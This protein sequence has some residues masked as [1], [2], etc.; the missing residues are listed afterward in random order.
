MA[1][2]SLLIIS[3]KRAVCWGCS[4]VYVR[5]NVS[6]ST[7]VNVTGVSTTNSAAVCINAIPN[8]A[9]APAGVVFGER[10]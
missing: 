7:H 10:K 8:K 3:I 1:R 2:P 6:A 5:V 9:C 4:P